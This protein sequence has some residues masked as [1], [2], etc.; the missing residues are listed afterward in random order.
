MTKSCMCFDYVSLRLYIASKS[1]AIIHKLFPSVL[2]EILASST[3]SSFTLSSSVR[4]SLFA[5]SEHPP[6]WSGRS[7]GD[8]DAC[9]CSLKALLIE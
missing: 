6:P 2:N 5:F 1:F 4:W 3:A 8:E 9:F 7:V